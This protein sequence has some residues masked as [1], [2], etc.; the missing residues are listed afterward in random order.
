MN[1]DVVGA[2]V[3][4]MLCG[5]M[6][7]AAWLASRA[8]PASEP[9]PKSVTPAERI[10]ALASAA[11]NGDRMAADQI[12]GRQLRLTG[13]PHEDVRP[14]GVLGQERYTAI[15]ETYGYL[16]PSRPLDEHPCYQGPEQKKT[17]LSDLDQAT[18]DLKP[19][20]KAMFDNEIIRSRAA[21]MVFESL[22]AGIPVRD[23][24]LEWLSLE[25]KTIA[26]LAHNLDVDPSDQFS[27]SQI[28]KARQY[29]GTRSLI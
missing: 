18:I 2:L 11:E 22:L 16:K 15:I 5:G 27:E 28:T 21:L 6:A 3:L 24:W 19:L 12:W 26:Q 7:V 20:Y 17:D 23:E 25:C 13:Y 8:K 10:E 14:S 1:P 4:G 29:V 9:K